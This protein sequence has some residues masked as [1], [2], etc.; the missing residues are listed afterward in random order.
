MTDIG[1]HLAAVL[2]NDCLP[3]GGHM[4]SQPLVEGES[5]LSLSSSV[6]LPDLLAVHLPGDPED[7][8]VQLHRLLVN[9]E[10]RS[11]IRFN[12]LES[13]MHHLQRGLLRNQPQPGPSP[14]QLES[15]C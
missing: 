13:L 14:G 6:H 4:S 1:A 10:Q 15:P 11:A 12:Q 3:P 7:P 9:E 2:H 5:Q 8:C